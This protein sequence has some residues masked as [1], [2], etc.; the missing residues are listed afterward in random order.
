MM[1]PPAVSPPY[2]VSPA[3]ARTWS[4]QSGEQ[5]DIMK[6][7]DK[8][9]GP[10]PSLA[11]QDGAEHSRQDQSG[12][13]RPNIVKRMTSNQNETPETKPDLKGPSVKRAA[14]NRDSSAAANRLKA[15]SLPEYYSKD[16]KFDP[17]NAV[18]VLSDNLEQSTLSTGE[19]PK[20]VALNEEERKT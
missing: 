10:R 5:E 1:P 19:A 9:V 7:F 12:L 13:P 17:E 11:E 3:I 16:G 15:A 6:S 8:D 14:L 4:G 18:N 20:Q 2:A